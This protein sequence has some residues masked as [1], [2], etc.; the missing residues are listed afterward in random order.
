MSLAEEGIVQLVGKYQINQN[1]SKNVL[2][3]HHYKPQ[4]IKLQPKLL[5]SFNISV[6]SLIESVV[7]SGSFN[8]NN[9]PYSPLLRKIAICVNL[10]NCENEI[11]LIATVPC[12]GFNSALQVEYSNIEAQNKAIA[13]KSSI[14]PSLFSDKIVKSIARSSVAWISCGFENC[15][16]V[17][18]TGRVMT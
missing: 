10:N 13:M 18:N 17:T 2:L 3:G 16:L 5:M 11:Q 9:D 8:T 7:D 6:S 12:S 15:A 14:R 1:A 4:L